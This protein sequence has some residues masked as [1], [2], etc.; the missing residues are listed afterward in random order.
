[1]IYASTGDERFRERLD[2]V[3]DELKVCQDANGDG[4]VGGVQDG[5]RV[6]AEVKAGDIR[7]KGFDLNGIWVPWYTEHST[8]TATATTTR[9][10]PWPAG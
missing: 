2:Y 6:F 8:C 4:Y 3:V 1:M 9:R 5:K 10:W 7:S